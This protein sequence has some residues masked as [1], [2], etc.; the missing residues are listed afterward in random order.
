[1]SWVIHGVDRKPV[2]DAKK[3]VSEH[4]CPDSIKRYIL[5]GIDGLVQL[6]GPEVFIVV[7]AH[8]HLCTGKDH[9]VT[10]ASISVRKG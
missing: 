9:E 5:D 7:D 1:M 3:I 2:E 8:G 10:S 4:Y 6:Y